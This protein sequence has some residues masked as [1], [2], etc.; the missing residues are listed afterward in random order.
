MSSHQPLKSSMMKLIAI[1]TSVL[2]IFAATSVFNSLADPPKPAPRNLTISQSSSTHVVA[3]DPTSKTTSLR[4]SKTTIDEKAAPP[5]SHCPFQLKGLDAIVEAWNKGEKLDFVRQNS[6][7]W[8]NTYLKTWSDHTQSIELFKLLRQAFFTLSSTRG[9]SD[10]ARLVCDILPTFTRKM[11]SHPLCIDDALLPHSKDGVDSYEVQCVTVVYKSAFAKL[12]QA[13]ANSM[14][15]DMIAGMDNLLIPRTQLDVNSTEARNCRDE[16][17]MLFNESLGHV[18]GVPWAAPYRIPQV[19]VGPN[20]GMQAEP[21]VPKKA[22]ASGPA[23]RSIPLWSDKNLSVPHK[24]QGSS[25]LKSPNSI[26]EFLVANYKTFLSEVDNIP[27]DLW[28]DPYPFLNPVEGGWGVY[29]L[30]KNH[31]FDE[32]RCKH[33]PRT[34]ELVKSVLPAT[35]LPYFHIY[36]EEAG[37][38]RLRP[39]GIIAPHSGPVNTIINTH[40]GLR[41]V[42]GAKFYVNGTLVQ[43]KEGEAFSFE[44]SYEHWG[45]HAPDAPEPRVIFMIRQMHP[46]VT[47]EHY[48]GHKRTQAE[49]LDVSKFAHVTES[50][51]SVHVDVKTK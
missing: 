14:Y 39:G 1:V 3:A 46:D 22:H 7:D 29:I 33:T 12:R 20:D 6:L 27:D 30:F 9:I 37:F 34:C 45:N 32:E 26:A 49:Q 51:E 41:G 5:D 36:N 19:L 10:D 17:A 8:F 35:T 42:E 44:D 25:R 2:I 4:L 15:N 18:N 16:F 50:V 28:T 40:V 43:W 47:Y 21:E 11:V 23:M 24:Q 38:F 13:T 31:T 48:K